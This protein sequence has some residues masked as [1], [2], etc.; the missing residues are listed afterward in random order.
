[1]RENFKIGER[2]GQENCLKS[3][4]DIQEAWKSERTHQDIYENLKILYKF[5]AAIPG[6]FKKFWNNLNVFF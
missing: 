2:L 4:L 6:V 1:M 5:T 3:I